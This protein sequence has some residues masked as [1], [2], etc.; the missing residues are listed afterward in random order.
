MGLAA[1]WRYA[2]RL[3]RLEDGINPDLYMLHRVGRVF[4]KGPTSPDHVQIKGG[5]RR[6]RYEVDSK[7]LVPRKMHYFRVQCFAGPL[8]KDAT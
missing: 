2:Y 7:L 4:A 3:A 8:L 5:I 6:V 1:Q